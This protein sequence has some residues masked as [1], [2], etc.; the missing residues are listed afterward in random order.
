[1][2]SPLADPKNYRWDV[3]KTPN[4]TPE[5]FAKFYKEAV[6]SYASACWGDAR[7]GLQ[8]ASHHFHSCWGS[9]PGWR[10][11]KNSAY[12]VAIKY[13]DQRRQKESFST[14]E[15]NPGGH[16]F[17]QKVLLHP[18][19]SPWKALLPY[20]EVV[21]GPN[22]TIV[23]VIFD[24]QEKMD[25]ID[26]YLVQNFNLASRAGWDGSVADR[27]MT[28]YT[29]WQKKLK[30]NKR[31]AY[32]FGSF[33]S[34]SGTALQYAG[35]FPHSSFLKAQLGRWLKGVPNSIM[36]DKTSKRFVSMRDATSSD[37]D[38]PLWGQGSTTTTLLNNTARAI[39][40]K[41]ITRSTSFGN[42]MNM[43]QDEDIPGL[44][45]EF[46]TEYRKLLKMGEQVSDTIAGA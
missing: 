8:S 15:T 2:S 29:D 24:N 10:L 17:I 31:E 34:K 6:E 25:E 3:K 36:T 46:R 39:Q 41:V 14:E 32:V 19:Y 43:I 20:L 30:I 37:N 38:K 21:Y 13:Y 9:F 23:G 11:P 1:M 45:K 12:L 33:F 44:F 18:K 26:K 22:D 28:F 7:K 42:R 4:V 16:W 27:A 40:K 5:V 35:G